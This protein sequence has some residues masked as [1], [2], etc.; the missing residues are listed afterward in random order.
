MH[1]AVTA[2]DVLG[3][4]V[5]SEWKRTQGTAQSLTLTT[6]RTKGA[7]ALAVTKPSGYVRIESTKL[8]STSTELA[9]IERGAVFAVDFMLP[10][11]QLNPTW[12]G[13]VQMYLSSASKNMS[14]AYLGQ[15][16]LTS[17]RT[18]VFTTL[19]FPIP[20]ATADIL[21]GATYSDLTIGIALN[22]PVGSQGVYILDNLRVKGKVPPR[23]TDET[24]IQPGQSIVLEAWKAYSPA[25]NHV[26][27]QTF[28]QGIIQIPGSFH[29]SKGNSA[30]GSATF[31]YRLGTGTIVA[32]QYPANSA[33]TDFLF[34]SCAGGARSGDLVPADFVR[35]TVVNGQAAA[36]KTKVKAQIALNPVDD[37]L[38]PGLP[39]IPTY[40][41]ETA[42]S[43]QA[44]LN[45]FVQAQR[46]WATSGFVRLHLPTPAIPV[47]D[48]VVRNGA[49]LPPSRDPAD[50][51]PPFALS[52]RLT[53]SDLADAGWHVTGSIAAPID[54]A[55]GARSTEFNIDIGADAFLLGQTISNVVGIVGFTKTNTP[56]PSPGS[57]PPTS[58]SGQFCYQNFGSNVDC[59]D[60][61]GTTGLNIPLFNLTP[62]LGL[63]SITYWI[64][65]ISA[66]LDLSISAT[67][68]GGFTPTGFALAVNPAASLT[69]TLRG[70]LSAAGFFGAGLFVRAQILGVSVPITA[71]VN[72]ALNMQPGNCRVHVTEG[73]SASATISAG[74]G[75]LGYY[76]EG[77][78]CCGCFV[79]LCWRDEG[80]LFSWGG[81]SRTFEILPATPLLDQNIP[82][83]V[84][85][86]PPLDNVPGT[87]AYPRSQEEFKEG[88]TS[89]LTGGFS[90]TVASQGSQ[91]GFEIID[92][93]VETWTSTNATDQITGHV[94]R[95][96]SPGPR[97]L[98]VIASSSSNPE[99][100]TMKGTVQVQVGA[101]D[102]ATA[103]TASIL[104]PAFGSSF[105]CPSAV[106]VNASASDPNGG[107]LTYAWY[108]TG[109]EATTTPHTTPGVLQAS[110][111]TDTFPVPNAQSS[112]LR[113]IV[114]DAD[115]NDTMAEIP[116]FLSC[117]K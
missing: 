93:D 18:G 26:A 33:G 62:H 57:V 24:Q 43:V 59:K 32:C 13:A 82:L 54:P 92:F 69:A 23:P 63:P 44:A 30:G 53:G 29:A 109:H 51:D 47:R 99:V 110:L 38:A 101:N 105:G 104:T 80:S 108:T 102:A 74:A 76:V 48:S 71:S 91:L 112:M 5:A 70:G 90:I 7:N 40:F 114:T 79:E 89:F 87:V 75:S 61:D 60:A 58:Y 4:E 31:E 85:L 37:N 100:G 52:G 12:F 72:A 20:N 42:A 55:T 46:T 39:P 28:T 65:S 21:K 115:G 1:G 67:L 10:T 49:N 25:E 111:A 50:N 36:G 17:L 96:G 78:I 117:I 84:A 113:L 107:T 66:G 41:G 95:Y 83:D 45:T 81:Y 14:N 27:S 3:F 9:K 2:S 64:F 56:A 19:R 106:P 88:D 116:M 15:V 34:G 68:T 86:C 77:G 22:V 35:L 16:E 6:T 11:Q 94:I 98:E 97:N 103:P 73:L 8:A